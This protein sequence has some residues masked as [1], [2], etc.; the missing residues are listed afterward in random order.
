MKIGIVGTGV[1]S[2]A[3]AHCLAQNT[4]NNI[5]MWSENKELVEDYK[6]TKKMDIIFKGK[7]FPNNITLTNSYAEVVND[8]E[9]VFLMPS[10]TYLESVCESLK[11]YLV[12]T[13]PVIIGTKGMDKEKGLLVHQIVKKYLKNPISILSGPTF[14]DDVLEGDQ[15][16]FTVACKGKKVKNQ[17]NRAFEN[18]TTRIKF[19]KDLLGTALSGS[20]KNI[21]AVGAGIIEGLGYHTSTQSYYITAAF[22][23]LE[24]ILYMYDANLSTLHSLAGLGDLVATCSS[25]KSRNYA[26]GVLLGK[27]KNKKEITTYKEKNTLEGI[28]SLEI[29]TQIFKKKHIKTPLITAIYQIV[30]ED[31]QP[32]ILMDALEATKLNSQL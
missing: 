17:I 26:F 5:I 13:I 30:F 9:L 32:Q 23:E 11:E 21:Y 10:L 1:F 25:N 29:V 15:V 3:M 18:T 14:A 12:K 28:A 27:K 31:A 22:Q 7:V 16:A 19:S 20:V 8:V 24:T 6:K 4:E 2:V